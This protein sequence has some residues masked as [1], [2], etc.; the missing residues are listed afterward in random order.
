MV[1]AGDTSPRASNARF[2]CRLCPKS[3]FHGSALSTHFHN[4]HG[5]HATPMV[6]HFCQKIYKNRARLMGHIRRIHTSKDVLTGTRYPCSVED[7]DGTRKERFY[8]KL[9]PK[10]YTQG[11]ALSTHFHNTHGKDAKPNICHFCQKIFKNRYCMIR[12][13]RMLH[14]GKDVLSG[15]RYQ[16]NYCSN[17]FSTRSARNAHHR[18]IH[19]VVLNND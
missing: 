3:Y 8:C 2:Q 13:M 5:K 1:V 7:S 18:N 10:S 4:T 17:T 14:T 12:H 19:K 16:C 6:C 9:C 11:S 15:K